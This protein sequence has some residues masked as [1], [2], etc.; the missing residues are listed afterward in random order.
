MRHTSKRSDL[1]RDPLFWAAYNH[2]LL[3]TEE[4]DSAEFIE[5]YFGVSAAA[6]N[7]FF[8][9]ELCVTSRTTSTAIATS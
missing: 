7:Q 1:L 6:V 2:E 5:P 4:A 8:L 3:P 9:D